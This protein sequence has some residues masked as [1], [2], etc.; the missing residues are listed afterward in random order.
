M[1]VLVYPRQDFPD[2]PKGPIRHLFEDLE[3]R[4]PM[5][6]SLVKGTIESIGKASSLDFLTATGKEEKLPGCKEPIHVL[7]LP[8]SNRKEG[9]VR[10]YFGY[11]EKVKGRI[12]ILSGEKK[13]GRNKDN[14]DTINQAIERYRKICKNGQKDK[15]K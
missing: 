7:K 11:D 1:E 2:D 3:K 9:V 10:L 13:H 14:P 6:F 4:N 8:P 15:P 5:L 12:W